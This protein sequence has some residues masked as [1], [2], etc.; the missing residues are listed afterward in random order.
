MG[1]DV[2]LYGENTRNLT[3]KDLDKINAVISDDGEFEIFVIRK[4]DGK[5]Y[6]Y[7]ETCLRYYGEMYERGQ[8]DIITGIINLM[9]ALSGGK[10]F[11]FGDCTDIED[12]LIDEFTREEQNEMD[13]YFCDVQNEPY[14]M[15]FR[16]LSK[17]GEPK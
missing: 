11:Y 9:R 8:W 12:G 5:E 4:I 7:F 13:E 2:E 14:S 1:I 15:L 16:K 3:Q 17:G 6:I 10:V